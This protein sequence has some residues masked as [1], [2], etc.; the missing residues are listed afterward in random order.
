MVEEHMKAKHETPKMQNYVRPIQLQASK[1]IYLFI[2][3]IKTIKTLHERTF[4]SMLTKEFLYTGI[5]K[6]E[7]HD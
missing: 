1:C 4:K 6:F 2:K 7:Y 3:T 5:Y